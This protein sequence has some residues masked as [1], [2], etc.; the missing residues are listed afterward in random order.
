MRT[1]LAIILVLMATVAFAQTPDPA[2]PV[3]TPTTDCSACTQSAPCSNSYVTPDGLTT[4]TGTTY[5]ISTGLI[6]ET[7]NWYTTWS[8]C[9]PTPAP[10]GP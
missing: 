7:P 10:A 5:C 4:C 2:P 8:S 9:G 6:I 1:L 3:W